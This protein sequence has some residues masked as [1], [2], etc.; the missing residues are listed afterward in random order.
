MN[1]TLVAVDLAKTE[2]E[3]AVSHEAGKVSK[4]VRPK[5]E[6]ALEFFAQL[7]AATVVMEACGTAQFFGS[8]IQKLGH[9]VLD[10]QTGYGVVSFGTSDLKWVVDYVHNQKER[11]A[12]AKVFERLERI[13][14][15][16][17]VAG[18]A[19]AEPQEAP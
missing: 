17:R 18:M 11:H 12:S 15:M 9:K 10:W 1:H 8:E 4:R 14:E 13:T 7:P 6:K 2:F 19:E 16:E 5:R 3:I